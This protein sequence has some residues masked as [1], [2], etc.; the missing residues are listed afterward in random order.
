MKCGNAECIY[1]KNRLHQDSLIHPK[2]LLPGGWSIPLRQLP[3]DQNKQELLPFHS[4][5]MCTCLLRSSPAASAH[6]PLPAEPTLGSHPGL[7]E[8]S[9]FMLA[10]S[11]LTSDSGQVTEG[12]HH[13]RPSPPRLWCLEPSKG[14][15]GITMTLPARGAS[16][17]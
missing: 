8:T 9:S 4:V 1:S 17:S 12:Q 14:K 11:G 16:F 2:M 13:H 5:P 6:S 10:P 7:L 3:A 15:D